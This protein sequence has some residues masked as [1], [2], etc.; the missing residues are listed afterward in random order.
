MHLHGRGHFVPRATIKKASIERLAD[1]APLLEEEGDSCSDALI[2][3]R[4]HPT[5]AN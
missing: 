2:A 5:G 1:A 4:A 3:Y